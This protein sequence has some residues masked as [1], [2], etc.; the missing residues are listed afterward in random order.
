MTDTDET[1]AVG[2]VDP[3]AAEEPL[4]EGAME[5]MLTETPFRVV[6]GKIHGDGGRTYCSAAERLCCLGGRRDLV[7]GARGK[8]ALSRRSDEC[9]IAAEAGNVSLAASAARCGGQAC[10]CTAYEL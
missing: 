3:E 1:G 5:G 10:K 7:C 4:E 2:V 8:N 6:S 9:I